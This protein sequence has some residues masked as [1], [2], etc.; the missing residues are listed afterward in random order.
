MRFGRVECPEDERIGML[1]IGSLLAYQGQV[2]GLRLKV[3]FAG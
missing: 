1:E 2:A 3:I